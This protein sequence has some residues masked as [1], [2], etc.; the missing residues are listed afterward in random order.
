MPNPEKKPTH[1]GF[2]TPSPGDI[3][4][5]AKTIL[6]HAYGECR[7]AWT[8]AHPGDRENKANKE[9][10]ARIAWGAVHKAGYSEVDMK[11]WMKVN[12]EEYIH[13]DQQVEII[14]HDPP[15]DDPKETKKVFGFK[16]KIDPLETRDLMGME[17]FKVGNWKG[18][19]FTEE[20][21][22][23]CVQNFKAGILGSEPYITIDHSALATKEFQAGIDGMNL[24]LVSDLFKMGSGK[25]CKLVANLKKVPRVIY[26]LMCAGA[27]KNK[28][29]ELWRKY[30]AKD[31][32]IYS[33]V[34]EAIT[35]T[36]K[37]PAVHDLSDF[38]AL[39]KRD[40]GPGKTSGEKFSLTS[41]DYEAM[42]SSEK[43]M[44]AGGPEG[45][46]KIEMKRGVHMD[47]IEITTDEYKAFLKL[48]AEKKLADEQ[49]MKS[50]TEKDELTKTRETVEKEK[51]ELVKF[52][53]DVE[54]RQKAN[55]KAEAVEFIAAQVKKGRILPKYRDMMVGQYLTF[56]AE[57]KDKLVL[58]KEELKSRGHAVK[59]GTMT[60]A[61]TD[62]S[63][64]EIE[65]INFKKMSYEEMDKAAQTVMKK[66][67][68]SFEEA[69]KKMGVLNVDGQ[70]A[71]TDDDETKKI[72][73]MVADEHARLAK[74]EEEEDEGD[75]E[76]ESDPEDSELV[77]DKEEAE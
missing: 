42:T 3:P 60:W 48:E 68:V 10:C 61:T 51:A 57:G 22:E 39:Y 65:K 5:H 8:K 11:D 54:I 23:E 58:F 4:D 17:I 24:G 29:V 21:L 72:K 20:D 32:N 12:L 7:S 31:G 6:S 69:L 62:M 63:P 46:Q 77:K 25:D 52:K 15:E 19:P 73:K 37:L 18:V 55:A 2:I 33:N 67:G 50:K 36:G 49:L 28:S 35:L 1:K 64:A 44:K 27:L 30:L 45:S 74:N 66:H 40:T 47:K 56:K 76:D 59:L 41:E 71:S 34:L 38:V 14:K 9:S 43:G 53:A 26:E 16:D 75:D 70:P 13:T